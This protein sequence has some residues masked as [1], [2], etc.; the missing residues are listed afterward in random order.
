MVGTWYIY[1]VHD[2]CNTLYLLTGD[3]RQEPVPLAP[4]KPMTLTLDSLKVQRGYYRMVYHDTMY[5]LVYTRYILLFRI[6]DVISD[7]FK[8]LM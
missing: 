1:T 8:L 2:T 7:V 5:N 6:P 3:E 4:M